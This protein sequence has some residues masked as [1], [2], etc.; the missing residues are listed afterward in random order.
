VGENR[1]R[2]EK[3]ETETTGHTDY[4]MYTSFTGHFTIYFS[5]TYQKFSLGKVHGAV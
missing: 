3:R 2:K 1:M 4:T 5:H